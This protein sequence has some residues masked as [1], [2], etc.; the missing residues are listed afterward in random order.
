MITQYPYLTNNTQKPQFYTDDKAW[1]VKRESGSLTD[2]IVLKL[3]DTN[4]ITVSDIKLCYDTT[5]NPNAE[6]WKRVTPRN[7]EAL[8]DFESAEATVRGH[9]AGRQGQYHL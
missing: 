1:S 6:D 7:G 3:Q 4:G 2:Y 9:S 5:G 8:M